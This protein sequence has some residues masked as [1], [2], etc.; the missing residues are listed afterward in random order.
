MFNRQEPTMD[1]LRWFYT[2]LTRATEKVY[3]V[4]FPDSWFR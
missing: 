2:A 1:Y 3:L 4:N